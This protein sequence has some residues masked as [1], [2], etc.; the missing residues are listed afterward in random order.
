MPRIF[1][2]NYD[3]NNL[4]LVVPLGFSKKSDDTNFKEIGLSFAVVQSCPCAIVKFISWATGDK[5]LLS[6]QWAGETVKV[7]ILNAR[8]HKP[9]TFQ[10]TGFTLIELDQEPVTKD[11]RTNPAVSIIL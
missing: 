10:E 1:K 5:A 8:K 11:W 3:K 7:P 6:D 2:E 4:D 9:G